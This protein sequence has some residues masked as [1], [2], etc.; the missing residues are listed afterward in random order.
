MTMSD[1]VEI[2][3]VVAG[4]DQVAV[5]R[6]RGDDFSIDVGPRRQGMLPE[7]QSRPLSRDVLLGIA[8]L[9]L[10]DVATAEERE[11]LTG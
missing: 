7:A 11:M 2:V 4:P 3:G 6:R 8:A 1:K 9:I 10:E 5:L